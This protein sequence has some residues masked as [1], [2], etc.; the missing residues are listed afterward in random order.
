MTPPGSDVAGARPL[1]DEVGGVRFQDPF[2]HLEEDSPEA[3]AWQAAL[4]AEA[5]AALQGWAGFA[6][7][8]ETIEPRIAAQFVFA[9]QER[10][11]RWFRVGPTPGGY[12]ILV[13]DEPLGDGRC[14]VDPGE[15]SLDWWE[16]SPA[17][18]YVVYGLSE[19]G[20]EQSVL[21]IVD[22]ESGDV[23]PD[24]IPFTSFAKIAWLPDE[25]GLYYSG[26]TAPDT[27]NAHKHVWFHEL[28]SPPPAHPEP[29]A[30]REEFVYPQISPDGRW[31]A[32]VAS[33]IETRPDQLL[34][35]EDG[36]WRRFL[37][38]LE[39]VFVG[40][41]AGDDY[42]AITTDGASNGRIVAIPLASGAESSGWRELVPEDD[43]VLRDLHV[44][45][46]RLVVSALVDGH[47]RITIHELDGT[48]VAE[49]PLPAEG[50]ATD[51]SLWW[52]QLIFNPLIGTA[53]DSFTFV[54]SNHTRSG[55]VYRYFVGS[56]ELVCLSEPAF[57]LSA[58]TVTTRLEARST[59]GKSVRM[60]VVHRRDLDLSE[61]RPTLMYGYGGWNI[62]FMPVFYGALTALLDAGGV[63][64]FA[65]LRGGGELGWDGWQEGRLTEKQRTFDDLY[66][67]A[68]KLIAD[69][70]TA[71][72]RLAV[73]GASNGGLLAAAAVTQRPDL[74]RAVVALVPVTDTVRFKR[75]SYA[76]ECTE[77][78]GD[79]D[80][81]VFAPV[82]TAYSPVHNAREGI[83]Y[84]ATLIM[85]GGG[86]IRCPRWHGRKLTAALR[87]ATNGDNPIHFRVWPGAA[88]GAGILGSSEQMA[89]WLG[90]IMAE[91]GLE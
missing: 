22:V 34:D 70:I 19:N 51:Q 26:G 63:L 88:H 15:S 28:G 17:G 74:W 79:P 38:D 45:A 80:D 60:W 35:R 21:R 11:G 7:L 77:E 75:D 13:A 12:G 32:L 25:T 31:V 49:V 72:D 89:E 37:L 10:G 67:A 8:R 69:G 52:G 53:S 20:D 73:A 1:A 27:E 84:P 30:A 55:A 54:F 3:L 24:E 58:E 6:R 43:G 66:A 40:K 71:S 82:L 39:G 68:E 62:A 78:Y 76:A 86:D 65:N 16:P 83:D 57:D 41:F 9:P 50:A 61:P 36:E 44:I 59:D 56:G 29:V 48:F 4:D 23:L 47:S 42:V 87:H 33:E 2:R 18:R 14:L 46:G 64:V 90:F 91:T 85:C 81:P 5:K